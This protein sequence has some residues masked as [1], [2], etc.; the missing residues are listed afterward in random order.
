MK[1]ARATALALVNWKGV[2]YERYLL[3]PNVTALEGANGAGKTTV[4]VA[5]YVVLLPDLSKL[6]FSNVGESG[7]GGGDRGLRGRL[8]DPARPSYAA[9][10][11]ECADGEHFVAGVHLAQR[12]GAELV[13]TPFSFSGVSLDGRLK[14]LLLLTTAEHD[15]VPELTQVKERAASLGGTLA[16]YP[17]AKEYFGALFE[18]GVFPLRL[19]IDEERRNWNELLRTSMSGGISRALTTELRSFLLKEETGLSDTLQ[20]MRETLDACRRTRAEVRESTRLEG[21]IGGVHEAGLAMFESASAGFLAMSRGTEL[22]LTSARDEARRA[23]LARDA[24]ATAVETSKRREA[25][26][27]DRLASSR[28][29][30][31]E[32][33]AQEAALERFRTLEAELKVTETALAEATRIEQ[34]SRAALDEMQS[35]RDRARHAQASARAA[36]EEA[37]EG[38]SDLQEGLEE[39]HRVVHLARQRRER[40]ADV[41]T[42]RAAQPELTPDRAQDRVADLDAKLIALER[43]HAGQQ[44]TR[45]QYEAAFALLQRLVPEA[46]PG[47]AFVQANAILAEHTRD[48]ARI[49]TVQP[50]RLEVERARAE[51]SAHVG[52]RELAEAV[53]VEPGPGA[54]LRTREAMHRCQ[55]E[56]R[57]VERARQDCEREAATRE[58]EAQALAEEC[59]ARRTTLSPQRAGF[60]SIR[61]LRTHF[62]APSA[63][64][65]ELRGLLGARQ[66]LLERERQIATAGL[67]ECERWLA[68]L[69]GDSGVSETIA[70]LADTLGGELLA[71]R[72]D[73]VDD[74]TATRVEAELGPLQS[75]IVV[76]DLDAALALLAKTERPADSRDEL[77]L[78]RADAALA[79]GQR[80]TRKDHEVWVDESYGLRI[81]RAESTG[82][83]GKARRHARAVELQARAT[84]YREELAA[85]AL[86]EEQLQAWT[87]A[88]STAGPIELAEID[89]AA[90][91]HA[92]ETEL[93]ATRTEI[94][95]LRAQAETLAAELE[96]LVAREAQLSNLAEQA[97]VLELPAPELRL[98]EAERQLAEAQAAEQRSKERAREIEELTLVADSLRDPPESAERLTQAL[99]T[100]RAERDVAYRFASAVRALGEL[101]PAPRPED[102]QAAEASL[103]QGTGARAAT[104]AL[105]QG[106][107]E[108]L[109]AADR[110]LA[111]IETRVQ[112]AT[113]EWQR[114]ALER[115]VSERQRAEKT[116]AWRAA[117]VGGVQS[118]LFSATEVL[119]VPRAE[120]D[121]ADAMAARVRAEEDRRRTQE[122][123]TAA[124]SWEAESEESAGEKR[125]VLEHFAAEVRD[126]RLQLPAES[127]SDPRDYKECFAEAVSRGRLLVDRL[128]TA[129]GGSSTAEAVQTRLETGSFVAAWTLA[130]AWL[131]ERLPLPLADLPDPHSALD[132]LRT[133]LAELESTLSRQET[134]LR[135]ASGDVARGIDVRVRRAKATVRRMNQHLGKVQFGSVSAIR[136][137]LVRVPKMDAVLEALREGKTQELLF[138]PSMPLEQAFEEIFRR[139]AGGGRGADRLL[140][141]R[142]YL[143]LAVMVQRRGKT[144]W[145]I[146]TPARLSTGEAIG[147]GASL[148]MV[149]LTEWEQSSQ[150]FR[151]ASSGS[152]R[153]LFLDEANRLSTDNLGVLFELC[154]KLSLQ[155]LLAAPEVAQ[156]H[157]NTTYRLVRRVDEAGREEVVVSGRRLIATQGVDSPTNSS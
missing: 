97:R 131:T 128:Q 75:A 113:D 3:D 103:A 6:R 34:A 70:R 133:Q 105:W 138:D 72:F 19:Q 74:E 12:G 32:R 94:E 134:D 71:S 137:D 91:L 86:L 144:E 125:K 89:P 40:E 77:V 139:F 98:A 148:L 4:M 11:F 150:M 31:A 104:M 24:A 83:L 76:D 54:S 130:R 147:V 62:E 53:G 10:E 154:E 23:Q 78:V 99:E 33:A 81:V 118:A 114:A 124:T 122:A 67:A 45:H 153:F 93:A 109:R 25:E 108:A 69:E 65:L 88:L 155:L 84:G 42:L 44:L 22:A 87:E 56:R 135:G 120:Q 21:E 107:Q 38:L 48:L 157:G 90:Q 119:D 16:V 129:R 95:R 26:A 96:K 39:L 17:S 116:A 35:T 152:L 149:V 59:S 82:L 29:R 68:R 61:A 1:R 115:E 100:T 20:R 46:T 101:G 127:S 136:V 145:E 117:D 79:V 66:L 106:H 14:E 41:T 15:E 102:V 13:L 27:Q 2:F 7:G 121:F 111:R 126:A 55:T 30:Y 51:Q 9:I 8:G 49:E 85:L 64:A 52:A 112:T 47:E 5:A 141:Y 73:D 60:R 80:S 140:D 123:A 58:L 50:R 63:N 146:A 92:R 110:E 151:K 143:E 28:A 156:A 57:E 43:R 142:E 132:R 37:A 36:Y 18:R